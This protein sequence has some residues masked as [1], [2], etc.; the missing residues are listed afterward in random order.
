MASYRPVEALKNISHTQLRGLALKNVLI[1]LQFAIAIGMVIAAATIYLQTRHVGKLD[2]GYATDG[3][4][5]ITT[6][7]RAGSYGRRELLKER[8]LQ[9]AG[10]SAASLSSS[11]PAQ[12]GYAAFVSAEGSDTQHRLLYS[13]ADSDFFAL[14]EIALLEGRLPSASRP[15]DLV[16][17]AE[18]GTEGV[19]GSVVL[20]LAAA[21]QLGWLAGDAVGKLILREGAWYEVV[22][23]VEDTIVSAFQPAPAFMYAVPE[24]S[25]ELYILS[26]KLDARD[27]AAG[28]ASVA[29]TWNDINPDE[30]L[31]SITV[32]DL[33]ALDY[34]RTR[35]IEK[36]V[37]LFAGMAVFISCMGLFGLANFSAQRRIKEIG[38]RKVMGG[39]VWQIV[40]LLTGDFSRLVLLSNLLAWPAAY[41]AMSRWLES[42]VYRIDLTPL[43]FIGSGLIALCIAWVTVG[44]TAAKAASAKPVLALR[45][46]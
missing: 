44:G 21:R 28:M 23:I 43:V 30:P 35:N 19:H 22:G 2:L 10:V 37:F 25:G 31:T 20:N 13:P 36:L 46:E 42:F 33:V 45:Y 11:T 39:S 1:V 14:Y 17:P 29:R 34:V 15:G 6:D 5:H 12:G 38:V 32:N 4:V 27:L 7:D 3:I 41:F 8:M 26:V 18:E 9:E 24:D 16:K 40:L